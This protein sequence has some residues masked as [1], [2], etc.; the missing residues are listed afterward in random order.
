MDKLFPLSL[1]RYGQ[2]F[3]QRANNWFF[4]VDKALVPI[5][6]IDLPRAIGQMPLAFVPDKEGF[7][8]VAVLGVEK[9]QSLAVDTRGKW[10]P[11][12]YPALLST[13]PF[14]LVDRD[15]DNQAVYIDEGTGLI[16]ENPSD[17]Q[18]FFDAEG[19]PSAKVREVV[20]FLKNVAASRLATRRAVQALAA[21]QLL[22]PWDISVPTPKRKTELKGLFYVSETR[23][24]SLEPPAVKGLLDSGALAVAFGQL[25]SMMQISRL[26]MWAKEEDTSNDISF[27]KIFGGEDLLR[28]D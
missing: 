28:F 23:L 22:E 9:H 12:Y 2:K 21:E 24:R 16:S 15:A 20:E 11:G 19:E 13:Y 25:F 26:I 17:G 1:E 18:P 10:R 6:T 4:A 27:E 5:V 8:L 7:T 14:C 3:W